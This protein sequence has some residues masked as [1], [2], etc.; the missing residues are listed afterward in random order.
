MDA[1]KLDAL[2]QQ[3]VASQTKR[4]QQL[5][6]QDRMDEMLR[7]T[8]AASQGINP[9]LVKVVQTMAALR[10]A[11]QMSATAVQELVRVVDQE[12]KRR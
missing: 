3:L 12:R 8:L 2:V 9:V 5:T 10:A 11:E 4:E 6:E 1:A 7:E